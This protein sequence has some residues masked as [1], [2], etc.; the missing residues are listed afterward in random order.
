MGTGDGSEGA[1]ERQQLLLFV[2][3]ERGKAIA[4]RTPLTV[5]C[6][7]R[8]LDRGR[9]PVVQEGGEEPEAPERRGAHLGSCCLPLLDTVA[10]TSHVVE[11]EVGVRLEGAE[12][13][14]RDITLA[15]IERADVA[16]GAPDLL[17]KAA[18]GR[19]ASSA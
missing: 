7:D 9:T 12:A 13:K 5:V 15:G 4:R 8:V 10:Q 19:P 11:K 6:E 2:G 16:A 1:E 14:G 18:P 3:R 17:E